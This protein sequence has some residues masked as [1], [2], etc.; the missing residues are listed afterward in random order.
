ME[1]SEKAEDLLR[2]DLE[3]ERET[4]AN[5]RLRIRQAEALEEYAL[6]EILRKFIAQE[7]EHDIDL[8]DALGID[9]PKPKKL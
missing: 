7:Q 3:N 5:Y 8:A 6:R 4:I 9:V 2:F 1:L